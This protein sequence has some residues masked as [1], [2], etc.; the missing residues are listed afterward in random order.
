MKRCVDCKHCS[1]PEF[2]TGSDV[3][4]HALAQCFAPEA[5]GHEVGASKS[6]VVG[7]PIGRKCSSMRLLDANC[8]PDAKW[9]DPHGREPGV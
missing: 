8:G 3:A 6:H 9:F 5:L 1:W 2:A 4:V 7:R